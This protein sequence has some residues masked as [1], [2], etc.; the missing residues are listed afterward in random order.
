MG[1]ELPAP[2][3]VGWPLPPP[4]RMRVWLVRVTKGTPAPIED[5][6][7]VR[8]LEH[9]DWLGVAWLPAD[10]QIVEALIARAANGHSS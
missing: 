1:E 5:H 7:A 2:D 4:Y 3:G 9:G 10:V 6:D 8:I